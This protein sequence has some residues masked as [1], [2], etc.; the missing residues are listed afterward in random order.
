LTRILDSYWNIILIYRH[1]NHRQTKPSRHTLPNWYKA[2][3]RLFKICR[4]KTDFDKLSYVFAL[5]IIKA[6]ENLK[7]RKVFELGGQLLRSG[8]AIGAL[9]SE[10]KYAQSRPDFISKLSIAR[11]EC[12]E[13]LYWLNLLHDSKFISTEEYKQLHQSGISLLK[14]LTAMIRTSQSKLTESTPRNPHKT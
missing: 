4:M 11:K 2:I 13:C 1:Q 7:T 8:T 5:S 9:Y 10:A 14:I 6:H 12:N 3:S